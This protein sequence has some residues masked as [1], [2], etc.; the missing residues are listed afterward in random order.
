M[1]NI[2][3]D[4]NILASLEYAWLG[5]GDVSK[6]NFEDIL[7][8]QEEDKENYGITPFRVMKDPEFIGYAAKVLLNV[9]LLPEQCVILQEFWDKP[10][11]M[12][13][14]TRGFGKA[15]TLDTPV[16]LDRGWVNM[17]DI[18]IGDK[19]YGRDGLLHTITDIYPQGQKQVYTL[20]LLDGRSIDC[21]E[22]HMWVIRTENKEKTY[23]TKQLYNNKIK[24]GKN[25]SYN[26][27]YKIP[28]CNPIQYDEK[29]LSLDPYILGCLLGDGCLTT[30]T[31]K[32]ATNDDFIVEEFRSRLSGFELKKDTTNNNW[33][34]VDKNKDFT[35]RVSKLGKV[36]KQRL[37]NRLTNII[38]SIGLNV[39][40]KYKFIPDEY[41][42]SS[43]DQRFELM[44]GLLDTNG[45]IN[46]N[47]SIEFTGVCEKLVDDVV[48]VLRSLGI[49]CMKSEDHREG[50]THILPQGTESVRKK[51]FRVFINTS[52]DIFKLPRK[53]SRLKKQETTAEKYVSIIEIKKTNRFEDMQCISVD[54][55]DHTYIT[56]DHIVTHNSFLLAVYCMLKM[57]LTPQAKSGDAGVK[58]IVIGAAFR[59]S[60]VLFDYMDTIWRHSPR[61]RSLCTS[62][63]QGPKKDVDRCTMYIGNNWTICV[64]LGDGSKIRG[65]RANIIIADEFDCLDGNSLV[66][67]D[68]GL[69]RIKD[70][71]PKNVVTGDIKCPLEK[72]S[73]YIKTPPCD[74]YEVKMKNGYVIRCSESHMV[75]TN[76]GWKKPLEL[77]SGDF[78]ESE[79]YY[80]FPDKSYPGIDEKISWLI[81]LLISKGYVTNKNYVEVTTTDCDLSELLRK[82]FGFLV[83]D[84][85][86]YQ[87]RRGWNCKKSYDC[88]LNDTAFRDW[89]FDIGLDYVKAKD[90][91]IPFSILQSNKSCIY[92]FLEGLFEG[93]GSCFLYSGNN[94]GAAYYSVSEVLC[95]DVQIIL[96]K[97][98]Y[99][100]Y[101][102]KRESK[103]S[104]NLQWFV[105]LNSKHA[106]NFCSKLNIRRFQNALANC[107]VQQTKSNICYDK[108][109]KKYKISITRLGKTIQ[110]R[111]KTHREA[112][113]YV[114]D[115]KNLPRFRKVISVKKL[116]KQ[117]ILYDYHLPITHS[118][119][120]NGS[121]QHNSIPPDI[122]E[123]VVQGFASVTSDPLE[124]VKRRA[125][126][127]ALEDIGVEKDL[128]ERSTTNQSILSGTAGYDFKHFAEYWRRYKKIIESKGNIQELSE[129]FID[130]LPKGF[131]WRDYCVIR[132]PCELVPE[133]FMDDAILARAKATTHTGLYNM[134][135]GAVFSKDSN[136][137]FKRSIIE[138]CTASENNVQSPDWPGWCQSSFDPLLRGDITKKY[139]FGVDP[140]SESDNFAITVLELHDN[141]AR[142]VYSWTTSRKDHIRR[143]KEGFV[144]DNDFYAYVARK[145]RELMKIFPC[146]HIGLD[147]QGGGISVMEALHNKNNLL[148]G[149]LPIWPIVDFE[150][151]SET[152]HEAGLHILHLIQFA[153]YEWVSE[154]NHGLKKDMEDRTILFPRFDTVSLELAAADDYRRSREFES[155]YPGKTFVPFDTLEDCVIEIEELKSELTTIVLTKT[156][157]GVNSRDRWDTPEVKL[158]TGKKGRLMK[159]RYSALLIANMIAREL[160]REL[161]PMQYDSIG[162]YIGDIK[163][164]VEGE[165]YTGPE[166]FTKRANDFYGKL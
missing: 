98:G 48:E 160:R 133:G 159:D 2:K 54:N 15:T 105:R 73:K 138:R 126:R 35:T 88:R 120:A 16:L 131:D 44:R 45:S 30:L 55:P 85:E 140:A 50:Q 121:R 14:A 107:V 84:R 72:P 56:K 53:R 95:R 108:D 119:Y 92:A 19:T 12:F 18:N 22:D 97:L 61:L 109:R 66:E 31:P 112:L 86:A 26:Y 59:Q 115:I 42:Y 60:K 51:Y 47:G 77:S 125:K 129:I 94:I 63:R 36:Y 5:L 25:G 40:C 118:F 104:K 29:E 106:Y 20:K 147:A 113:K 4:S 9:D 163:S 117:D 34:I 76:N 136:G 123:T 124:G 38:K 49:S 7:K 8:P 70:F 93:D 156:G 89:L 135:Y 43:V 103:I 139:V 150:K 28:N 64:P 57:V 142:V 23:T 27:P 75:M 144:Q 116:N 62:D 33:T 74:V 79:N 21:C 99:D 6:Y 141:H 96:D 165:F 78:I 154:A 71:T 114:N 37:H 39:S 32:I 152:D 83:Y 17:G 58:I 81:G 155:K 68:E 149:D 11:P 10:F 3:S 164:N 146:E 91:K 65:L 1:K 24:C 162:G 153:R 102:N 143:K 158:N 100:S 41:K 90:K 67:T 134:E 80:K 137:F 46:K 52:K 128:E 132:I 69:I 111:F 87:D 13:V 82:E 161:T 101:I 122:Y 151:P 148:P 110:K 145:I 166:W 127:K 157:T 130:G